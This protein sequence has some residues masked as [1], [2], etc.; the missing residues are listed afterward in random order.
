MTHPKF[1]IGVLGG[2]GGVES[3]LSEYHITSCSPRAAALSFTIVSVLSEC[4]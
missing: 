3:G 1:G 2:G 4:Y